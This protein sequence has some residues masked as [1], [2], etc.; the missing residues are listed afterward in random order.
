[1]RAIAGALGYVLGIIMALVSTIVGLLLII[2]VAHWIGLGLPQRSPTIT[3]MLTQADRPTSTADVNLLEARI[4]NQAAAKCRKPDGFWHWVVNEHS[5]RTVTVLVAHP[6]ATDDLTADC[7][8]GK[9]SG[10]LSA[11]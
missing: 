9:I 7:S 6:S 11:W 8:T 1:V 5:P 4:E 10:S 2:V 3:V